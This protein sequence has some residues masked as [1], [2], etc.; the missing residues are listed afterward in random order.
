MAAFGGL[1][2]LITL[3]V[4]AGFLFGYVD[5]IIVCQGTRDQTWDVKWKESGGVPEH[6]REFGFEWGTGEG[7]YGRRCPHL[8]IDGPRTDIGT[9]LTVQSSSA[10]R[11]TPD[12]R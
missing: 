4:D 11:F 10:S 6:W 12:I 8:L 3:T 2:G 9:S 1:A 5:K 7:R